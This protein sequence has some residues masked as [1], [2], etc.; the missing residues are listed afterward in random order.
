MTIDIDLKKIR[1][2][3]ESFYDFP[4]G[5]I[6]YKKDT[7]NY[8]HISRGDVLEFNGELYFILGNM[9][10][11][12][13]TLEEYPKHWVKSALELSTKRKKVL[14]WIF[15]EHFSIQIGLL[16]IKCYRSPTKE[17]KILDL[18]RG[19]PWFMKGRTVR[20][21]KGNPVRIL[22]YIEGK[23]LY[24]YLQ[25]LTMTHEEYFY[26]L[27][28]EILRKILKCIEGIDLLHKHDYFH[29]DIRNDHIIMEKN[30]DL[31]KWIDFDLNQYF[32][33]FDI[34]SIGNI[35]LF[36]MGKTEH[37]FFN[38]SKNKE[39]SK[40]AVNSLNSDDASAFFKHRIIN[41]R[42]IFPYIPENLNRI[43]MHFSINTT[44]FYDTVDQLVRD[45]KEAID[46][47]QWN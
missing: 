26:T 13:F 32:S 15:K 34:W 6:E 27:Y 40:K 28:P 29:G 23:N 41:L 19:H 5:K 31:Y 35:L 39:I 21:T 47:N 43:L 36:S 1:N 10:E 2:I 20:D 17:G 30:T 33:D 8:I 9:Y 11:S 46:K 7:S 16:N 37:T 25:D 24:R 42:K 14:K 12:R 45:I 22:D 18:T 4:F 38:A 44:T 3:V